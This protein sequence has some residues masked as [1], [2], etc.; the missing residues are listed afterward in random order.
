MVGCTTNYATGGSGK[1]GGEFECREGPPGSA[2]GE[3]TVP[4]RP[5]HD[6]AALP[7]PAILP[8]AG[9]FINGRGRFYMENATMRRLSLPLKFPGVRA[10]RRIAGP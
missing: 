4:A 6:Y 7:E 10:G 3:M 5:A 9:V 2:V 8:K 1:T